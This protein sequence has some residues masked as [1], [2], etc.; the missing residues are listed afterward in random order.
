MALR[1]ST[2]PQVRDRL[3]AVGLQA[4]D[5]HRKNYSNSGPKFPPE[6]WEAI[7]CGSSMNF[8]ILTSGDLELNSEMDD[9]QLD[10]AAKL[11]D[12]LMSL[13]VL[14]EAESELLA[15]GPLFLLPKPGQPGKW[16]CLSDMKRGWQ[17]N[18]IGK[19]PTFLQQSADILP[20]LYHGGWSA[21]ADG[22]TSMIT[23][24]MAPPRPRLGAP[25]VI[26]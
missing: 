19:D 22:V 21:V 15:N 18:C 1:T 26:S 7:R 17:N 10:D 4:L 25:F 14:V 6:H 12:E 2:E 5:V 24:Y 8:L 11:V 16:W 3:Y 9:L 23:L 20:H 13:G